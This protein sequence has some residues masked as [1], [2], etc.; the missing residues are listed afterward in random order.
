MTAKATK[1]SVVGDLSTLI[2]DFERSLAAANK[3]PRTIRI[4]GDS[5]RWLLEFL[6]SAGMSTAV[7]EIGREQIE[8]FSADQLARFKPATA[9]Q[10]YRALA[11]LWKWLLEED[12]IRDNPFSRMH[13]PKVPESPVPVI[14]DDDLR[15]LLAVCDGA[16]FEQRRDTALIRLLVDCGVRSG[17]LMNLKPSD[18]DRDNMVIF[19]VGKGRRPRAV[20]YGKKTAQAIDRYLRL[21][22]RHAQADLPWLWLAPKGRFTDW[23]LRQMLN[24]RGELAGIG[25]VHPHQ[26]RHTMAHRWMAE[27][28]GESDLMMIAGW[29]SRA[30]LNRYGASAA[31]ERAKDAHRRLAIGDRL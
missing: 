7:D 10:R 13:P 31:A 26:F 25:H 30:M 9:S 27:G 2:G 12:E 17:E 5:A 8:A 21:R 1:A 3:A 18:L 15:K 24:R 20:P 11:Q 16:G 23:G 14:S 4:Y 28:G 22:G 19:V 6:G 29:R